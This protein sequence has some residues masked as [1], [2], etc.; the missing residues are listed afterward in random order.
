MS[1]RADRAAARARD[2][3]LGGYHCSEA[4][5]LAVG[6]ELWG[7]APELL[8]RAADGFGGGIALTRQDL[9]G[10]FSG[11]VILAGAQYGRTSASADDKAFFA[12]LAVLRERFVALAGHMRCEDARAAF[13]D[14]NKRCH[15][16]VAEGARLVMDWFDEQEAAARGA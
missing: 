9:C 4:I 7:Q 10:I 16:L 13:P 8:M 11:A 5:V 3:Y 1:E 6:E 15:P 14:V 12:A 2:A